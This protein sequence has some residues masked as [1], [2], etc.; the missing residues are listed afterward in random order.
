[1]G[2]VQWCVMDLTITPLLVQNVRL[3]RGRWEASQNHILIRGTKK[4]HETHTLTIV[5]VNFRLD[6]L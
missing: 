4:I 3:G 6:T 1:M 2:V 5:L